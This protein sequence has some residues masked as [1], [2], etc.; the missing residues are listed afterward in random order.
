M[1]DL[2]FA[3]IPLGLRN[4]SL[5]TVDILAIQA[6]IICSVMAIATHYR[7]AAVGQVPY[8]IWV[9]IVTVLQLSIMGVNWG[10][11]ESNP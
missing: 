2:I 4:L 8:F 11:C 7:W 10:S 1:A 9:S 5:A 3:T 6:T